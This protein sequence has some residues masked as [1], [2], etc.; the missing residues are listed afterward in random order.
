MFKSPLSQFDVI[1]VIPMGIGSYEISIT[2]LS[3]T[4]MF[5]IVL[6]MIGFY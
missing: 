6:G 3:F 1:C 4:V 5:V 2:N